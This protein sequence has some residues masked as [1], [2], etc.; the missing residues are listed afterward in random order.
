[1][2]ELFNKI[3]ND[4]FTEEDLVNLDVNHLNEDGWNIFM[5]ACEQDKQ[6]VVELLLKKGA[7][8]E[9]EGQDFHPL[10]F[11]VENNNLTLFDKIID[12]IKTPLNEIVDEE[13][14]S[15][16]QIA[17]KKGHALIANKIAEK[18]NNFSHKNNKGENILF[19]ILNSY[20][21]KNEDID[22]LSSKVIDKFNLEDNSN[23]VFNDID[24]GKLVAVKNLSKL[25]NKLIELG[26][27]FS[28]FSTQEELFNLATD[29]K[30]VGSIAIL[31][32]NGVDASIEDVEKLEKIIIENDNSEEI[33]KYLKTNYYFQDRIN[34][35]IE[36]NFLLEAIKAKKFD[37]ANDIIKTGWAINV[38]NQ[39]ME[40]PLLLSVKVESP[41]LV[42]LLLSKGANVT[43]ITQQ[44]NSPL[45]LAVGLE[46]EKIV[47]LLLDN[48]FVLQNMQQKND[49]GFN[50]L[51]LAIARRNFGIVEKLLFK[52]VDIVFKEDYQAMDA[53]DEVQF[54]EEESK[55]KV[56][57]LNALVQ[58]GFDINVKDHDDRTILINN[59]IKNKEGNIRAILDLYGT[60][61]TAKDK[62]EKNALDY[63]LENRDLNTIKLL[64][65]N[66]VREF[67]TQGR[68]SVLK[69]IDPNEEK[70][71]EVL[72]YL[73]NDS[74]INDEI[75][76]ELISL[77]F[78]K[79]FNAFDV[80]SEILNSDA[81]YDFEASEEVTNSIIQAFILESISH[82]KSELIDEIVDEQNIRSVKFDNQKIALSFSLPNLDN[83]SLD[84]LK[85]FDF[86]N[87]LNMKEKT[88]SFI[89]LLEHELN[90]S[91][92]Y[93]LEKN[94]LDLNTQEMNQIIN[95][96]EVNKISTSFQ[97]INETIKPNLTE[98]ITKARK[99][100]KKKEVKNTITLE[101]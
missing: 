1:M 47:D 61:A 72:S 74:P 89:N 98:K 49:N 23:T 69:T 10:L 57:S 22:A 8:V 58:L 26:Y 36:E 3:S 67:K 32:D 90:D 94:F 81:E 51:N 87:K 35:N 28:S 20:E 62:Y 84:T 13:G 52:G 100:S 50:A 82:N 55:F 92:K 40:T 11:I 75:K 70:D 83:N 37:I 96:N 34:D 2:E 9:V 31:I 97:F 38:T 77:L 68:N 91:I 56:D 101:K 14:N 48:V 41:E 18:M 19:S 24:L 66:G 21:L 15:L 17:A 73:L 27:K 99:T 45:L 59:V 88:N 54:L 33:Y 65:A 60:D 39:K 86:F 7:K 44:G 16:I 6:E 64:V 76:I 71:L 93:I 5:Y 63:A 25:F 12:N 4:E 30:S 78:N 42:E 80:F 95:E 43:E 53:E 85:R 46:N 79:E 29:N